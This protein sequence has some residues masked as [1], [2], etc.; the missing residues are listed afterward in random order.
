MKSLR[1]FFS[2]YKYRPMVR[3]WA[4]AGPILI[5][6]IC[7]PLL[8]PL[9]H[10]N[11]SEISA[12]ETLRLATVRAL[13]EHRSLSLDRSYA[14]VPGI[15][16]TS[17]GLYSSQPPMMALLLSV[18]AW[19]MTRVGLSFETHQL[20]I[21]YLLTLIGVTL[22]VAAAAGLVYRM[23]R[24]FELKR[25][26]RA[27][28]GIAVV[29]GSGLI[30]Y[31]VVLNPHA[32]AAVLLLASAACLI[33]VA[34]MN[35]DDRR[36]G[37]FA[38]A[39]A[40]SA[41]AATIDPA[42][43]VLLVLFVFVIPAMRFSIGRRLAG[44]ML[45]I[46][47]AVPVIALHAA[48]NIPVTGDLIP[49]SVHWAM[50]APGV[51]GNIDAPPPLVTVAAPPDW[52]DDEPPARSIWDAIGASLMWFVNAFAGEHGLLSHFPVMI[53][54]ILGIGAVMHR[55]WPSS[56]KTLAATCGVGAATIIIL[57]RIARP[58]WSNA[59]FATKWFIVFSPI[60]LFW[61]GAWLRRGHRPMSWALA[62]TVFTFSCTVGLLGATDPAP[63]HGF[64]RYTAAE[65]ML[66]LLEQSRSTTD[67]S[68]I[69]AGHTP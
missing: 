14:K 29:V 58:D 32:P 43:V 3:P 5:L 9:R 30:S 63:R 34:A 67:T 12:D 15:A 68:A 66:K 8:R 40:C 39:G 50:E 45:Y 56:T 61:A 10:P 54:G 44:M 20:L 60:L 22:P 36:A 21:A 47:G 57:Y 33:H 38:L 7:L 51:R 53:L 23:G 59:M 18:P 42:A 24:L 64:D 27:V 48:W 19:A 55:H 13:V 35:R 11:E 37:W 16:P 49:Q 26:W 41:L 52:D 46:I 69:A 62:G 28:L 65:A 6:C 1:D 2:R 17:T 31:A 25:P 4:L